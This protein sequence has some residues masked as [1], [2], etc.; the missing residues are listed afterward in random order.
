MTLTV[1][2]AD[3]QAH[4]PARGQP[5]VTELDVQSYQDLDAPEPRRVLLPADDRVR[6]RDVQPLPRSQPDDG[7]D[8]LAPPGSTSG[9]ASRRPSGSP[10]SPSQIQGRRSSPSPRPDDQPRR[11]R[12]AER[13]HRRARPTSAS[14][15]PADCPDNAKIGTVELGTP[16]LDGPL[17]GSIYFGEPKPGNQYRLFMI[18]DGFGIHAKLVGILHPDPADRP[19]HRRASRTCPRSRSTTSTSTSSPPTAACWRPRP[20]ARSTRS[21]PTS[22]PGTTR[23]PD[24]TSSQIFGLASGPNGTP[25]PGQ[26]RPFNPRLVAGTS[27]PLAGAFCDFH[28]KLDRDDGDQFL[29]DLNFKMPP[30]LHRR[31]ARDRLLPGGLDRRRG[32]EPRAAPSRP[33]RAARPPRQIGTTNVAAGPGSH[34]F[35]AVGKMYLA[36][37]FKG[38]P[39]S[40]SRSPRRWPAPMTTAS[41]SSASRSTSIPLTP[42]SIAVSDTVPSDH[43]RRPDPD[44]LD[45]GQHRQA[46]LH[47]QPDQL[48]AV[49]GRLPGN[50]RPGHGRRLLLLLPRGQLRAPFPSSRRWRSRQL[51][52]R[53][54]TARSKNPSLRFDLRTRPGDA[55]IKS[56]AVTL[57]KAFA[58]DQ[59]H[60]GNI[61]SEKEL[62]AEQCAGRTADRHGDDHDAAARP[63]AH[64]APSTRSRAP[65]ACRSSPSSST[66][67]ST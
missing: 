29:G 58:I 59:R 35:H 28:L 39:L 51:G 45:P 9:S 10:P 27:N 56:L 17:T 55:N 48:L 49:L 41:S 65:A 22:S 16:A 44:A 42:R 60:L 15:A 11:G 64:A 47:D 7:A 36:G 19:A 57:P 24:Q 23:S 8:R 13:L 52:G 2:A 34:P 18:A 46:Q 53:K 3:Q 33:R 37:P 30:G 67:R 1:Q 21:R 62:A 25:C 20:A 54:E 26:V 63:A 40:S 38:A 61:C 12:R 50:R 43:R 31:P 32:P 6:A 66:A 5:L 14:K 4:R